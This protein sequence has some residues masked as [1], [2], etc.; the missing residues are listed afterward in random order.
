MPS[1]FDLITHDSTLQTHWLKRFLAALIDVLLI[2]VPMNILMSVFSWSFGSYFWYLGGFISG[3]I[4]F[5]YSVLLEY[6]MNATIGKLLMGLRVVS[7][8]GR[9]ELFQVMMRN[10]TKVFFLF[11][12]IDFLIGMIVETT[13]PRQ[14]YTDRMAGTSVIVHEEVFT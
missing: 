6:Q 10:L 7:V 14:R 8:T 1:G 3:F 11:L 4:W 5:I 12:L 2:F 9:L 13:D